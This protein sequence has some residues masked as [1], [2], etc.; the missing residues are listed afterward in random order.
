MQNCFKD[1]SQSNLTDEVSSLF[2][3]QTQNDD[4]HVL[5]ATIINGA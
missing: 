2:V 5:Y 4:R 3:V 1:L